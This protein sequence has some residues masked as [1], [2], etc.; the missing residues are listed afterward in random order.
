MRRYVSLR[1]RNEFARLRQRGRRQASP[2]L[3][4]FTAP[5][6]PG[7]QA[8]VVG[9]TVGGSVGA[10]VVRNLVR[11]RL[12]GIL[13]EHFSARPQRMRL[14]IIARPRAAGT[15]Y[16]ELREELVRALG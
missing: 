16:A 13:D 9:I 7:D 14:L 8:A 1:R 2:N 11:R 15:P 12:A 3:T 4:L 6:A 10:A 5:A